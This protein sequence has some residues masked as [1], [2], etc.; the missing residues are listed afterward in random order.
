MY[1]ALFEIFKTGQANDLIKYCVV[2]SKVTIECPM[3]K[4]LEN[5]GSVR[6]LRA[7][8]AQRIA[9]VLLKPKFQDWR[10]TIV[11]KN[12]LNNL[13]ETKLE[14]EDKSC[15]NLIN[16]ISLHEEDEL[17]YSIDFNLLE[18]IIDHLLMNLMDKEYI[19]RWSCAKGLGRLCERLT[20]L[21][22]EDIYINLFKLF[23]DEENEYSWQGACLCIAELCKRGMILPDKL[24]KLIPF[25]EKALVFEVNKGTFCSGSIVRDSACYV[26][27]A[28]ARAYQ[29]KIMQPYVDKLARTLILVILFDKEVNCRRAASAAFQ[30]HVGR[31]GYFPHGIEIIT[32]ADY[33]TLGNKNY[34][35]LNITPFIS[36]YNEYFYNIVDY[37]AFNRLFHPELLIRHLSAETLGLLANFNNKYFIEVVLKKLIDN[38]VSNS[39]IRRH[40]SLLG[41]G[42]ILVGL[43][44]KWDFENKA[45]I[46]RKKIQEG[47]CLNEKKVLEDSQYRSNF[48][49]FY[50]EI[51]FQNHMD[52]I[53][54][55]DTLC[56]EIL[57]I[58]ETIDKK[59]MYR[60]KGAELMRTAVILALTIR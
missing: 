7:K 33:F 30:E 12:L 35:Y 46:I 1:A 58:I 10:Y 24:E 52:K 19:V 25:L 36:Q 39:L 26:V 37:I 8:L 14:I 38:S 23:D 53:N 13:K 50:S 15:K 4:H 48:E 28:L 59:N 51:K 54:S 56:N 3:L 20:K 31:Q 11:H 6:R 29:S 32:E 40:G 41:I 21:M 2:I 49:A 45:K 22:V 57:N 47:L 5:S 44:G 55:N 18:V 43:N 17:D 60:G 42:Y 16:D 34:C 9:L 27:W